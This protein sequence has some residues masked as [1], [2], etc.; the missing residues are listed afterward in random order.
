[1]KEQFK[2]II[3]DW[4]AENFGTQE[5]EDPSWGIDA[6]AE[7]LVEHFNKDKRGE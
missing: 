5:A 1:M 6:L 7:V 4:V 2:K 3:Y